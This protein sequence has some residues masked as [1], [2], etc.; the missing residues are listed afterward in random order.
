M[1]IK[2]SNYTNP[3][4]LRLLYLNPR[5]PTR[6]ATDQNQPVTLLQQPPIIQPPPPGGGQTGTG[7]PALTEYGLACV[8]TLR[9]MPQPMPVRVIR[10]G[11]R[12]W[13]PIAKTF[14]IVAYAEVLKDANCVFVR[15]FSGVECVTSIAS[16]GIVSI[17]DTKGRRIYDLL[18]QEDERAGAVQW[19]M[20]QPNAL[21]CTIEKI[22]DA[23]KHDVMHITLEE[24][25][26]ITPIYA[27][28]S[29]PQKMLAWHNKP[30]DPLEIPED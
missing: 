10:K 5:N 16:K 17:D 29:T 8:G 27:T 26:G 28:G 7:C 13:N 2:D 23:G 19:L 21:D 18:T 24:V 14:G 22:A 15:T 3:D 30:R 4:A 20:G 9:P 12:L 11:M 6:E 25:D 1:P